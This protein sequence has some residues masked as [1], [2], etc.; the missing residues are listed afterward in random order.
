MANRFTLLLACWGPLSWAQAP[1]GLDSLV[2]NGEPSGSAA[3]PT[4][5]VTAP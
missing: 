3:L 4:I 5:T 1:D 2:G